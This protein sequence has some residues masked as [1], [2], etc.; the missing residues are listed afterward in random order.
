MDFTLSISSVVKPVQPVQVLEEQNSLLRPASD[1][2]AKSSFVWIQM[3]HHQMVRLA[4]AFDPFLVL[5][6]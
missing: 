3:L 2:K 4:T 1:S 6:Q 5:P